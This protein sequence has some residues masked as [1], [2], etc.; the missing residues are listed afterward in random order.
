MVQF[1]VF[2]IV[3]NTVALFGRLIEFPGRIL[4][5]VGTWNLESWLAY[6]YSC[7]LLLFLCVFFF[8]VRAFACFFIPAFFNVYLLLL[9]VC[10]DECVKRL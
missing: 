5:S 7:R 2:N 8:F 10:R 6:H 3:Y 1:Y 9:R 4:C